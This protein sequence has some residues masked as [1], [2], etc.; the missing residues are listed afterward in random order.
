MSDGRE[1]TTADVAERLG[2]SAITARWWCR[3]GMFPNAREQQTPRGPVW[4]IPESDLEGFTP[5]K[6]TGRPSKPKDESET[7][8]KRARKARSKAP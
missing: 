7:K 3:R 2:V 6:R 4:V 8:P 5:P 1:L